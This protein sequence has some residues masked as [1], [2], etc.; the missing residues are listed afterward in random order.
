MTRDKSVTDAILKDLRA[1]PGGCGIY[2]VGFIEAVLDTG[3]WL[4]RKWTKCNKPGC[5]CCPHGPYVYLRWREGG[6]NRERYIG[7]Y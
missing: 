2:G 4:V 1:A 5:T 7:K 3:G 6:R